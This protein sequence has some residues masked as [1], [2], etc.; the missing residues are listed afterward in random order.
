ML[1]STQFIFLNID[2]SLRRDSRPLD[3][4]GGGESSRPWDEGGHRSQTFFR[5]FGPHFG[6]KIR[7]GRAPRVLSP[8]SVTENSQE[9]IQG[10]FAWG[11]GVPARPSLAKNENRYPCHGLLPLFKTR[12]SKKAIPCSSIYTFVHT[13]LG[14]I[15]ECFLLPP[16]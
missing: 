9:G 6:L 10:K 12:D 11:R 2:I 13:R 3:K 5:P 15:R 14:Q 1:S 8:G 16:G 4:T 7:G